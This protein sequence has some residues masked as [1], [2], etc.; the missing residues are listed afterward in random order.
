MYHLWFVVPALAGNDADAKDNGKSTS[1]SV[2]DDEET[3]T[4]KLGIGAESRHDFKQ[5]LTELS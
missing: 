2:G 3:L 4:S 1:A 5:P